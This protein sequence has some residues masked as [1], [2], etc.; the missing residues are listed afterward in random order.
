M[1]WALGTEPGE[2]GVAS[3]LGFSPRAPTLSVAGSGERS[4]GETQGQ[5]RGPPVAT[6]AGQGHL[7]CDLFTQGAEVP[8]PVNNCWIK[9]LDKLHC[10][11]RT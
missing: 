1:S 7:S 6:E 9:S 8:G 10:S 4:A 5:R 3:S 11:V 2:Q